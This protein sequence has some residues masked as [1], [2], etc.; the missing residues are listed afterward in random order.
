MYVGWLVKEQGSKQ[1]VI[2]VLED[3]L[4]N[5]VLVQWP[6]IWPPWNFFHPQSHP[7]VIAKPSY[8]SYTCSTLKHY[9]KRSLKRNQ[10][11]KS[12]KV[13]NVGH[14]LVHSDK[15]SGWPVPEFTLQILKPNRVAWRR[16]YLSTHCQHETSITHTR[17]RVQEPRFTCEILATRRIGISK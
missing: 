1:C 5:H 3:T 11:R 13:I 7:I 12:N 4:P 16:W 14:V 10:S 17:L 8:F 2:Q 6:R 9:S 15:H